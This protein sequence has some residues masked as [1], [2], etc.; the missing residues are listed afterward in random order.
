ADAWMLPTDSAR[1]VKSYWTVEGEGL[2]DRVRAA[3][4]TSF[5]VSG[6]PFAFAVPRGA[7]T[8]NR[9]SH[10]DPPVHPRSAAA[11]PNAIAKAFER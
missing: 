2:R 1:S 3:A 7:T 11:L 10:L 5:G 4:P 8:P 6:G 9:R